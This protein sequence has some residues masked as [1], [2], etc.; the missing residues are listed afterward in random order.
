MMGR[1]Q[2]PYA[3]S[4]TPSRL[5]LVTLAGL[6]LGAVGCTADSAPEQNPP[7]QANV[8]GAVGPTATV[9]LGADTYVF[10]RVTCDL[11]DSV[12]DDILVRGSGTAPDG[13]RMSFEVERREVGDM[14]HDRVTIYFGN[15]VEGNHWNATASGRP[16][17][18][19]ATGVAGGEP[20]GGPLVV[21]EGT[22]LTAE[23]TFAH[24][25]WDEPRRGSLQVSCGG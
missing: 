8:A 2:K 13:E 11:Q 10:D 20:L 22:A 9:E 17:G 23:G 18:S 24:E 6:V 5:V 4:P 7:P 3:G 12:H 16:G 25:T 1:R 21:L 19:W 14:L 15:I